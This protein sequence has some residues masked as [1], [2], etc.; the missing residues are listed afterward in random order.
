MKRRYL[1]N[2]T[3]VI[4]AISGLGL[5]AAC[6]DSSAPMPTG[7]STTPF[8][9]SASISVTPFTTNARVPRAFRSVARSSS[10]PVCRA[11]SAS[12]V[13]WP[14]A[15]SSPGAS[16]V[17]GALVQ[18][19]ERLTSPANTPRQH[20]CPILPTVTVT[21]T[22]V[23]DPRLYG[24]QEF[25]IVADLGASFS[26]STNPLRL[27]SAIRWSTRR[28]PQQ[29]SLSPTPAARHSGCS[30]ELMERQV[31]GRTSLSQTTVR[32]VLPRARVAR[33]A[34]LSRRVRQVAGA[35]S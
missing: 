21:A 27:G 20:P 6:G 29:P 32:R 7:P 5:F 25:A 19:A 3:V 12:R 26:F 4:F 2:S 33:S 9:P 11:R 15:R 30:A 18:A 35:P 8:L 1:R 28:A 10:A 34:S 17:Q 31:N 24:I 13:P 16:P 22:S 23:A 14:A